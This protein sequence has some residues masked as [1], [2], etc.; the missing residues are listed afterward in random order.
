MVPV[1]M[2]QLDKAYAAFRQTARE[3]A[4]GGEGSGLT[5]VLA[6]EVK[7]PGGLFRE[8][9]QLRN[10]RLHAVRHLV[11]RDA[12]R[13]LRIAELV[14]AD[15]VQLAE[16][17]EEGAPALPRNAVGVGQEQHGVAAR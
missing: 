8:V 2:V 5:R 15:G 1:A 12:R 6:V 4:V 7:R 13:D 17:I 9:G 10:R 16:G 14:V 11:L 3:D